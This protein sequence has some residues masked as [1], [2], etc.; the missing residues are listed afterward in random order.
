MSFREHFLPH[1]HPEILG[2]HQRGKLLHAPALASYLLFLSALLFTFSIFRTSL[3]GVLG[4]ATNINLADLVASTNS[5]RA[6]HGLNALKVNDQLSQAAA[7]KAAYMFKYNFWA[8]VAPDG[9]TPWYFITTAGYDYR[10]AGENLARD[11]GDSAAVVAAWMNSPSHR[12]N[13]LNPNYTDIGFAAVNGTLDGYE[14]TLVVQM[15]GKP[16]TP[17][18]LANI[19]VQ[20]LQTEAPPAKEPAPKTAPAPAVKPEEPPKLTIV[21]L[22]NSP[23]AGTLL[24]ESVPAVDVASAARGITITLGLFLTILFAID[25]VYA[26]RHHLLRLS[27][28]TLAHLVLLVLAMVGI[29]YTN[30]GVIV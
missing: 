23:Q 7:A 17:N 10:Y 28:S 20:S 30:V 21:P 14:T 18:Y 15:F 12:E 8:H 22:D 29:W 16:L 9:T 2:H 26:W 25:G 3:P 4:F 24:V 27:G 19:P 6:A 1:S 11:F 13:M 5:E